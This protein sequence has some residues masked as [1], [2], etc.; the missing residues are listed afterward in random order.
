MK[1]M[2]RGCENPASKST[3][4]KSKIVDVA[5]QQ[6]IKIHVSQPS[7]DIL[8][9]MT[10]QEDI[11][12][13]CE[14]IEERLRLLHEPPKL[15]I[16]PIYSSM[17]AEAQAKIFDRAAPGVRKVIV[18]TNIAETSLTVDGIIYV[19]DSGFS[20]LKVYNARMG[21]VSRSKPFPLIIC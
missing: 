10:G 14:L 18:A 17:P 1:T 8:C 9:F 2:V 20:K 11:E 15:C 13:C 12:I 3:L 19:V 21:M 6:I 7:G 16:L 5:V 4:L